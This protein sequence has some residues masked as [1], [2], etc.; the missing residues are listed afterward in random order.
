VGAS[1][2]HYYLTDGLGST[3]ALTDEA[4]D[5]VNTYDYDVFGAGA[6]RR[7]AGAQARHIRL[8]NELQRS[9]SR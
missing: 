2:T 9:I 8:R 3:L 5:I 7:L 1:E 4:G 6:P